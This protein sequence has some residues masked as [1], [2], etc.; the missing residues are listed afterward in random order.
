LAGSDDEVTPPGWYR[1]TEDPDHLRWWDG[2][3]WTDDTMSVPPPAGGRAERARAA[4][5]AA[6]KATPSPAPAAPRRTRRDA[7]AEADA[8]ARAEADGPETQ[9]VEIEPVEP[10]AVAILLDAK[11]PKGRARQPR[12]E[13][14]PA[15]EA[16]RSVFAPDRKEASASASAP[17]QAPSA[18]PRRRPPSKPEGGAASRRQS[19]DSVRVLDD[20]ADWASA[21]WDT[22]PRTS[23]TRH[24]VRPEPRAQPKSQS[25]PPGAP[26]SARTAPPPARSGP[27]SRGE[28]LAEPTPA[29][30]AGL[31][32]IL[33]RAGLI[34]VVLAVAWFG[35]TKVRDAEPGHA[36]TLANDP[37]TATVDNDAPRL[38]Q[39]LLTLADLPRGWSAQTT[40]PATDEICDGRK[41]R[42]VIKPTD[43]ASAVFTL[44]E[45]GT[46][47]G[48]VVQGFIDDDT[49]KAFMDL[50]ARTTDAC[51]EY[52]A[53]DSTVHL[54]PM[55]FPSFGDDTFVAQLGGQSPSGA[56]DGAV[57]YVRTGNRVA[58]VVSI[59]V[60]DNKVDLD[61][62]QHLTQLV[63]HR[64][65]TK[66]KITTDITDPGASGELPGG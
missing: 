5:E 51:R 23:P 60:G 20:D 53:G 42:S 39:I 64:M 45:S 10:S 32:R 62:L 46:F 50:T 27:R 15:T 57:V 56:V 22:E 3:D 40:D 28:R 1:Q 34:A 35:Y 30:A 36:K 4:K 59:S 13:P 55:S 31:L 43:L 17:A 25:R 41:P 18:A 26:R 14:D 16:N 21:A 61:L 33:V 44:G 58:S 48:N 12:A 11:V 65:T 54:T 38:D 6:A 37:R 49:A 19:T 47:I 2:D 29:V 52:A 66:P 8:P 63:S 7:M 24:G 9:V